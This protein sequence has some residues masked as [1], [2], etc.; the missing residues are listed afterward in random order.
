MAEENR[1][2]PPGVVYKSTLVI[3]SKTDP[4]EN[5]RVFWRDA[6]KKLAEMEER[7]ELT[8]T[9]ADSYPMNP[10]EVAADPEWDENE[11]FDER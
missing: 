8:V 7:G 2:V 5:T 1:Q 10:H 9:K 11:F 6:L 4:R 3:W